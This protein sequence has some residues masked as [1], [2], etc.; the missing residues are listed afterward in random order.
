MWTIYLQQLRD[1]QRSLRFQVSLVVLVLFFVCNGLV[2]TM[3]I[4]RLI[5]E[6]RIIEAEDQRRYDQVT[7]VGAAAEHWYR[8][9]NQETGVEFIAE[10]GFNW[11]PS[12][13]WV[14]PAL[15]STIGFQSVRTTNNWM[16]RFEVLDWTLIVRYVLS[17]LCVVLAYNGVSGEMERGT[18]RL[19][20]ANPLSRGAFLMGKFLA[21]LSTLVASTALGSLVSLAIL[22]LGGLVELSP[23]LWRSYALFLVAATLFAALFLLLSLAVSALA[24]SSAAALVFLVTAWTV[25]IVVIPQG[26][27]LIATQ[28]VEPVGAFW[29][30]M[31]RARED[32]LEALQREGTV[33]RDPAL[34]ARDGYVVERRFVQRMAQVDEELEKLRRAAEQQMLD[35]Y[36]AAM[37]VNLLSPG[38]AFQYS[39]EAFLGAGVQWM[40]HFRDQGQRYRQHLQDFLRGRD[41]ADPDSP[42]IYFLGAFLSQGE[43]DPAQIPRFQT[44]PVPFSR[45][46]ESSVV[47]VV[48]LALETAMAFF[49]ALWALNRADLAGAE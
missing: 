16:R 17:F 41:A 12:N 19:A 31:G 34:A 48:V 24:R 9:L 5:E 40:T 15:G 27:Y 28:A 30:P 11:F 33:P 22:A 49:L 10:A 25:L 47:P 29:E 45:R 4:E 32:A 43:L 20:L 44:T 7:T 42:H 2:Y 26:S 38:Y 6:D 46:M 21:H 39:V 8:L 14:T 3:K 37:R 13:L 18:L 23:G 35:Q 1:N 36:R